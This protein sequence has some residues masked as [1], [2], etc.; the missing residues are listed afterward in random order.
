MP[1]G[2]I[3]NVIKELK[4]QLAEQKQNSEKEIQALQAAIQCKDKEIAELKE[5]ISK[6]NENKYQEGL[7]SLHM[8]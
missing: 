3:K 6:L 7:T 2:H 8:L 5:V 4:N 1:D